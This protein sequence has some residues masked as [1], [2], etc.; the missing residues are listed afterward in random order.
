MSFSP[1][2]SVLNEALKEPEP[3]VV[4]VL[5]VDFEPPPQAARPSTRIAATTQAR[6]LTAASL[7]NEGAPHGAPSNR[8]GTR[9][10]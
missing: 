7:N 4:V 6:R 5:L 2:V 1:A 3:P 10:A 8:T 9:D